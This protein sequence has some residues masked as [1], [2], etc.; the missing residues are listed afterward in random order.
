MSHLK[1]MAKS[2]LQNLIKAARA[3][4]SDLELEEGIGIDK[5]VPTTAPDISQAEEKKS[6]EH[7]ADRR[8]R[9]RRC[10]TF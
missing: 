5:E 10:K 4:I 9:G 7:F 8:G 6:G 2:E 1:G 3:E